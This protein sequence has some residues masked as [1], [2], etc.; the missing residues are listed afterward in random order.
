M[1]LGDLG[2]RLD[3]GEAAAGHHDGA[4]RQ[5][6]QVLGQQRSV[7][8][9]VQ[10]VGELV[11]TRDDRGVGDAAQRIDQGVVAQ[12]RRVVDADGAC[13][14]VEA[15]HPALDEVHPGAFELLGDLQVG[16][17]LAGSGL[18]QSQTLG[19]PGLRVDQRD[20]DVVAA[21]EPPRQT[22]GRGHA[23]VSGAENQNLVHRAAFRSC[24]RW[25][26]TRRMQR[27]DL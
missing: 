5:P 11:D 23:G 14:G 19:E 9:A 7:L 4:V 8:R 16:Q 12:C 24:R 2:R 18:V 26:L 17:R 22:H 6:V 3:A 21:L 15:R 27:S 20:V 25:I 13:I 10:R 1:L